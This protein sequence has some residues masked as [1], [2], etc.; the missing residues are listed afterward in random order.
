MARRAGVVLLAVLVA[1]IAS[2]SRLAPAAVE[3]ARTPHV[4]VR[5]D[6]GAEKLRQFADLAEAAY[7]Q[8]AAYFKA[9]PEKSRLPLVLDASTDRE[10]FLKAVH[11]VGVAGDLAG[12]GGYYDPKSRVSFLY[13]QPHLS[14]TRLL[15]LHELTHQF[16]AKAVLSDNP[17]R[18]P[19]W[20]KEG[21]AEHFGFHRRTAKGLQLGALDIV[22]I[23]ERPFECAERVASGKFDP[24]KIGTG[25]V[26]APDYTDS[27]ALVETLLRT[28]DDSLRDA[29]R[30][31][32]AD[33]ARGGD[34]AS[35][36]ERAFAGKKGRL[37][38]AAKEVWGAFRR[39]WRIVYVAWDEDRG[40]ILGRGMPWAL[41]KGTAPLPLGTASVAATITLGEGTDG[42]GIALGVQGPD[43]LI[44]ADV[45]SDGRVVLRRKRQGVWTDL[46]E[47]TRAT[48]PAL[49]PV[50]IK[51]FVRGTGLVLEVG[52]QAP[53]TIDGPAAGLSPLDFQGAAGLFVEGGEAK[54]SAVTPSS[55]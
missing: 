27:L 13:L 1:A 20:H 26:A 47:V 30:K 21:L 44:A 28:K 50:P 52:G 23:D 10:G 37:E 19:I 51:L 49:V 43:H 40:D 12:A 55:P 42:A 22:A 16:Q 53:V 6:V 7:P 31:F 15:V 32:E 33:I 2:G 5:G 25:V 3:E 45:R 41:L 18:S 4:V 29:L 14:S 36:F 34:P 9:E 17:D 35:K 38:A 8:W 46:H 11:A 54:F 39:P 24:W 48:G